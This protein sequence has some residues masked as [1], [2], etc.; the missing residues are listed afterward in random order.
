VVVGWFGFWLGKKRV[1]HEFETRN[2]DYHGQIVN[3]PN[4]MI[5]PS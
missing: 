4:F 5:W 3:T 2:N 1:E